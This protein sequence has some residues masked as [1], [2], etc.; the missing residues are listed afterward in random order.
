MVDRGARTATGSTVAP[1]PGKP[2]QGSREWDRATSDNLLPLK[3]SDRKQLTFESDEDTIV[4]GNHIS[5][6]R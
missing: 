5:L 3:V 1:Q 2:T 6:R 4:T